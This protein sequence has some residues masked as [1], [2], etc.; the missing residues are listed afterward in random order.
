MFGQLRSPTLLKSSAAFTPENPEVVS[1]GK[2]SNAQVSNT[3]YFR[4]RGSQGWALGL[5]PTLLP[6][7]RL[8][9]ELDGSLV[10]TAF[11]PKDEEGYFAYM[12][13]F[14]YGRPDRLEGIVPGQMCQCM[15]ALLRA[16]VKS[17][18][19]DRSSS[20]ARVTLHDEFPTAERGR[21]DSER[22]EHTDPGRAENSGH[23]RYFDI[24]HSYV[25]REDCRDIH[26][27]FPRFPT[28]A[29]STIQVKMASF[30]DAREF[31]GN[32][33]EEEDVDVISVEP[34]AMVVPPELQDSPRTA[35]PE[36]N[37]SSSVSGGCEG[38][39]PSTSSD[40]PTEETPSG[41]EGVEEVGCSAPVTSAAAEVVVFEG[42]E[43]KVLSGRLYNLRKAPKTLP[44]GFKFKAVLHHEVADGAATV[45]GYKK[46]EEMVRRFQIPRTILIRAG[47]P[48]ERACSVSRTGWV[49]VYV[50]HFDAGLRFPLLGLIFDVLAEY[51][52]ALSQ[53]T[54]NSIMFIIGFMLLCERL[55]M[56]AKAVVF[57]SLFLCRL[58]PSTS[59]TRWYYIS[60]RE[61]MMIFT[62]IRNK[63]ARWKR[64]FV[65]VRDTRTDRIN[66][67]L[68]ARLSEWRTPNTY[69]NY[70]QLTSGD[71]DLK[72]RLLDYVKAR[73]LVDL[74]TLV[75][76][77][78]IALHGFVDVANLHSQGVMSSILERQRQRA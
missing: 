40:S 57:R 63:V 29:P 23:T 26:G 49:L 1:S 59:G 43:S 61:K 51:E 15:P 56:P 36:S 27:H 21:A 35:A 48:N 74:E 60:G 46:L 55:G 67:E 12:N 5:I 50:D 78:Q 37:T 18:F 58:C 10:S 2:H 42:W 45:K 31:R 76:L 69:M 8:V 14:T 41:A 70:P 28:K 32:Q 22:A 24:A 33:G 73:G 71:V 62:N 13:D 44:A 39:Q 11:G 20:R 16:G 53:L 65:F 6:P 66:N 54:P 19:Y 52:L 7:K 4:E 9:D 72:N 17:W 3:Q 47:T 38:H 34:I 30:H 68:A 77:E 25:F 64:Q 75:T